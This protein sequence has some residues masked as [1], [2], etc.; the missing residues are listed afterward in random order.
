M[1][2]SKRLPCEKPLARSYSTNFACFIPSDL[3]VRSREPL[4]CSLVINTWKKKACVVGRALRGH[5]TI[6]SESSSDT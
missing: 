4:F 2:V 6:P 3:I 5:Q 1:L